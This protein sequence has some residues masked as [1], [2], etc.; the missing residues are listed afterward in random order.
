MI[1][2]FE[3]ETVTKC[4]SNIKTDAQLTQ[5]EIHQNK[6]DKE[7]LQKCVK[8][9]NLTPSKT[10]KDE[11][12]EYLPSNFIIELNFLSALNFIGIF[13]LCPP[14]GEKKAKSKP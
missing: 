8:P 10:I 7:H 12:R 3:F 4:I 6:F 2:L 11:N 9:I 1:R 13:I 14:F 5:E